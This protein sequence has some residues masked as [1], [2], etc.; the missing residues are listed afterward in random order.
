M[1][2]QLAQTSIAPM[3]STKR[4]PRLWASMPKTGC[5]A[6]KTIC[7]TATERDASA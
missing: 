2:A 5:D 6:P 4:L 7:I 3:T 1:S